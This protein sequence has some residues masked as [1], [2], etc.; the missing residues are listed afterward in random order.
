MFWLCLLYLYIFEHK[1][2]Y[3]KLDLVLNDYY[4]NWYLIQAYA[5]FCLVFHKGGENS[6]LTFQLVLFTFGILLPHF[7]LKND[8]KMILIFFLVS[9]APNEKLLSIGT[10]PYNWYQDYLYVY[11]I[12]LISKFLVDFFKMFYL[13][14]IG[15][16]FQLVSI[17]KI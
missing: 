14:T 17:G 2:G 9:Y 6:Y 1:F 3:A 8:W 13:L 10:N 4:L 12:Q 11:I 7:I 15:V 5:S 16:H